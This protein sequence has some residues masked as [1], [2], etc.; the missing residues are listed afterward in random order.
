[1]S[2]GVRR[3]EK[4]PLFEAPFGIYPVEGFSVVKNAADANLELEYAE[5]R[6]RESQMQQEPV[7]SINGGA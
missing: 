2:E 4:S 1:M 7:D 6:E 3:L 5:A